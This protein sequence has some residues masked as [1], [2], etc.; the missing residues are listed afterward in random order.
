MYGW[1]WRRLPGPRPLKALLAALLLVAVVAALFEWV[2][3]WLQGVLGIGE[4]TVGV[5]TSAR[6]R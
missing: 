6:L 1:I 5:T 4:V 2:F 3:P